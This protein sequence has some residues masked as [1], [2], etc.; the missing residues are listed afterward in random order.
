MKGTEAVI[1]HR[2]AGYTVRNGVVYV[3]L[4]PGKLSA[5]WRQFGEHAGVQVEAT[6]YPETIDTRFALGLLVKV[7]GEDLQRVLA[8]AKAFEKHAKRVIAVVWKPGSVRGE[9]QLMT[10]TDGMMVWPK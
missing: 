5:D 2:K 10:D 7:E 6:D 1:A 3:D 8:F 9:I 4:D